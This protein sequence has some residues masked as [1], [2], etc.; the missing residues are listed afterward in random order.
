MAGVLRGSARYLC[1]A[2]LLMLSACGGGGGGGG[3]TT[4]G[5]GP[6][7]PPIVTL[8][9]AEAGRFLTQATFGETDAE[10]ASLKSQGY[11]AWLTQQ[12]AM[13]PS[14]SHQTYVEGRL[15]QLKAVN[16]AA[17]LSANQVYE[18][19]WAQAA[20]GQ[21]QLRQ[22]VKLALSE[23]FV[24][25]LNDANVDPRGAASYYD[26]LGANAFGNFRD[27]LQ[28]VTLHP[29]MGIYLTSLA[30]QKED[31]TTG[32]HPDENYAREVMQLMSLG[33]YKLNSDGTNQLDGA[34]N[35]IPSYTPE[36]ISN[37]AKV[38]TGMSWYSPNPTNNTFFG[39]NR[40]V[41]AAVTPMIFYSAFHSIS[42]KSFLGVTI[43]AT[44]TADPSGDLK[45]ALDT[46]F[47]HPNVGPFIARRL[48]QSLVTSNPSPAYIGR[49]AAAFNNNGSGTRG[50][51][52]AVIRAVLTDNEARDSA[53]ASGNNFGKVREPMVR[54]AN[55]MR[56]F[57][58]TSTS[59]NFLLTSTSANTSLGQSPL[60]APS[61]FNFYRPGYVP[62]NTRLGAL[63]LTAPELQIVDEVTVAGYI[64]TMQTT[65]NTGIG[66]GNDVRAAYAGEIAVA[67][68]SNALAERMNRLLLYGQMPAT[69]KTRIVDGI[70]GVV[71]PSGGTT[72]QAQIDAALLNRA[73]LA[74]FMT[75][76]SPD[77]LVQR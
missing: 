7:P 56:T 19:F 41:D 9:D 17:T 72:T 5:T 39:G 65:I 67:N 42:A 47:N 58:A 55:W 73:K 36:D 28:N 4:P 66:T 53:V 68:D 50:D 38:F 62:P 15:V 10:I 46:I 2:V 14:A 20:T 11:S 77:Y 12:M 13:A 34:G 24:I 31:N 40:N 70:N 27:L 71:I 44:T 18:T 26:M 51:M 61:V 63:N 37:L 1:A 49:V 30:N 59:G 21:D 48:I 76:A 8:T 75:M 22:R 43:P 25:S 6:T 32:R 60:A 23:I 69:L 52:A 35:P 57:G 16:P 29:M 45:I 3:T 74:V 54:M 33:V 64:N